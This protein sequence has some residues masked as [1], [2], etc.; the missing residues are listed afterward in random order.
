MDS[1]IH[2]LK[3]QRTLRVTEK[4]IAHSSHVTM[5]TL[6]KFKRMILTVFGQ[7]Y[8]INFFSHRLALHR[9]GSH[10]EEN[11]IGII[12][13]RCYSNNQAETVFRAVARL[14]FVK[15]RLL[16]LGYRPQVSSRANLG[17]VRITEDGMSTHPAEVSPLQIVH[18]ILSGL[19]HEIRQADAG[20][21]LFKQA[22][23]WILNLAVSPPAGSGNFCGDATGSQILTHLMVFRWQRS[24]RKEGQAPS[25]AE[26][27]RTRTWTV[28]DLERLKEAMEE[29]K[30]DFSK[31]GAKF[32]NEPMKCVQKKYRKLLRFE[33]SRCL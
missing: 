9:I 10:V 18:S 7:I 1:A 22:I 14:E 21:V 19:G 2:Q 31:L 27:R 16:A 32:P 6:S 30:R 11:Y 13:Q 29:G 12:R 28:D 17:G 8:A 25:S 3:E 24:L 15:S 26:V 23:Q 4:K 33:S 20:I 5:A